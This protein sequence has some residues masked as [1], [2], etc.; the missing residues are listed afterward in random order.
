MFPC[1]NAHNIG[2]EVSWEESLAIAKRHGFEG[3][4]LQIEPSKPVEYYRDKLGEFGMKLGGMVLPVDFRKDEATYRSGLASLPAVAA[5]AQ[6]IGLTRFLIWIF[7]FSDT[8]TFKENFALHVERLRPCAEVFA[9]HGC[10]LGLEFLGPRSLRVGH[11]YPFVRTLEGMLELCERIGE[12]CGVLLD[13]WH[14]Y[15]SLGTVEDIR[16]L[17]AKDVVYVHVN[18]APAGIAVDQQIDNVRCLPGETGVQDI[19]GFIGALRGIGYD[20]PVVAEPFDKTLKTLPHDE[21][22]RRGAASLK[23]ILG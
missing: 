20:G 8:L 18:D 17:R 22:A 23:K 6:Q 1:L 11:R 7:S 16:C 4:D 9:A 15:T 12:N 2:I 19:A 14:W 3:A 10:R 13:S 21:A 5:R